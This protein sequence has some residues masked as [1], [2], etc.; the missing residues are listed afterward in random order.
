[1]TLIHITVEWII[2]DGYLTLMV[3]LFMYLQL[4]MEHVVTVLKRIKDKLQFSSQVLLPN[5]KSLNEL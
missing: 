2:I 4:L 1:M 5:M 3:N